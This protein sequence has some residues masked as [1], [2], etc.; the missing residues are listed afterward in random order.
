MREVTVQIRL[1]LHHVILDEPVALALG[2][3]V[4][5]FAARVV[6]S[7]AAGDVAH[8]YGEGGV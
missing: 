7:D 8:A 4:R 6:R 3:Q 2:T 1:V 5:H